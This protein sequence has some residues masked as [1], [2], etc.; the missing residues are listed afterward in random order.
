MEKTGKLT[1]AKHH[2]LVSR[3]ATSGLVVAEYQLCAFALQV[4][5]FAP[6]ID[7]EALFVVMVVVIVV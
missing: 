2:I 3:N 6:P 7:V 5:E 4:S 1:R